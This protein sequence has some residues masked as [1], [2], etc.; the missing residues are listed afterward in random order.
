MKHHFSVVMELMYKRA[1]KSNLVDI[2]LDATAI[3]LLHMQVSRLACITMND[4]SKLLRCQERLLGV[5]AS[6]NYPVIVVEIPTGE[7]LHPMVYQRLYNVSEVGRIE[8]TDAKVDAFSASELE[9]DLT[10]WG[11]QQLC[12]TGINYRNSIGL[13]VRSALERDFSVFTAP[14]LIGSSS[15]AGKTSFQQRMEEQAWLCPTYNEIG[16]LLAQRTN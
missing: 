8:L 1:G 2:D 5:C 11:I 9:Q 4:M 13:T 15:A 6:K 3:L 12:V 10:Y 7:E 16:N 14:E